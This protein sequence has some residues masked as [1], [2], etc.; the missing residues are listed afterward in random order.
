M[1][2][3]ALS[4]DLSDSAH[5]PA[6]ALQVCSTR[7]QRSHFKKASLLITPMRRLC[8]ETLASRVSVG[9]ESGWDSESLTRPH[10]PQGSSAGLRFLTRS[11]V[12]AGRPRLGGGSRIGRAPERSP[13]ALALAPPS[14]RSGALQPRPASPRA[15]IPSLSRGLPGEFQ[16]NRH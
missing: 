2:F 9:H 13:Q 14:D 8:P 7:G 15:R 10:V 6:T 12:A 3:R 11:H 16:L 5:E 1:E 4:H